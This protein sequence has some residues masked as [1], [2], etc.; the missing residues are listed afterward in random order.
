M[1][2]AKNAQTM[3]KR[4]QKIEERPVRPPS[5]APEV[6]STNVVIEEAPSR[7]PTQA[8]QESTI[9]IS[10]SAMSFGVLQK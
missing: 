1:T 5:A 3:K 6:D 2:G 10:R 8:A 4:P 7:P 9:R